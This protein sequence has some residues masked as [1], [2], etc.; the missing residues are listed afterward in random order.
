MIHLQEKEEETRCMLCGHRR[1]MLNET[2]SRAIK[3]GFRQKE[4]G[5]ARFKQSNWTSL[6]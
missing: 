2:K 4:C 3:G 1:M 5:S 6:V